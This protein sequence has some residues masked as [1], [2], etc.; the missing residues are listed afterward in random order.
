MLAAATVGPSAELRSQISRIT[1]RHSCAAGP[2]PFMSG[3]DF[4]GEPPAR[5]RRRSR[6]PHQT[7]TLFHVSN[8]PYCAHTHFQALLLHASRTQILILHPQP[9]HLQ[10]F[11]PAVT[12]SAVSTFSRYTFS[13]FHI[14]SLHIQPFPHSVVTHS[15]VTRSAVPFHRGSQLSRALLQCQ[16]ALRAFSTRLGQHP[17]AKLRIGGA[18]WWQGD[19]GERAEGLW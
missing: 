9:L 3:E 14:Q 8:V 16:A 5:R 7:C 18:L 4:F 17:L 10:P 6:S 13:R 15:A 2:A 19:G 12:Y 11:H 1:S